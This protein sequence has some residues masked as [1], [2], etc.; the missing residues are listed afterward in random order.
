MNG[1]KEDFQARVPAA[2][3]RCVRV[4]VEFRPEGQEESSGFQI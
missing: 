4:A 2:T 1:N 3:F